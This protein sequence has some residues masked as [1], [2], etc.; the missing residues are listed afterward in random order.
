MHDATED[1]PSYFDDLAPP[2]PLGAANHY[3]GLDRD[4]L[5]HD[6]VSCPGLASARP[7]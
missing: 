5:S 6:H 4:G 3:H 1:E 2:L 7:D